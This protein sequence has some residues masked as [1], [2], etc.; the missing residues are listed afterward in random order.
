MSG[1]CQKHDPFQ[2]CRI[3]HITERRNPWSVS[4]GKRSLLLISTPLSKSRQIW[5]VLGLGSAVTKSN[6][7]TW[8]FARKKL[9]RWIIIDRS[10]LLAQTA[11]RQ[12]STDV[13]NIYNPPIWERRK[14]TAD[15]NVSIHPSQLKFTPASEQR[16]RPIF[17][18]SICRTRLRWFFAVPALTAIVRASCLRNAIMQH[19][20]KWIKRRN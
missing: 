10:D 11:G 19:R 3:P 12:F 6:R 2:L 13:R 1:V 18:S 4:A 17:K 8:S 5:S 15:A 20:G 7:V 16:R 14:T 9:K